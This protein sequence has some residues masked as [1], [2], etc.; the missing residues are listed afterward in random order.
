MKLPV[1]FYKPLAIGAPQPLRELP[2][3]PERMIQAMPAAAA[4]MSQVSG[5]G[6]ASL[7]KPKSQASQKAWKASVTIE[8]TRAIGA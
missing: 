2:V 6:K 5:M 7:K 3:R 4:P 8:N 1:H